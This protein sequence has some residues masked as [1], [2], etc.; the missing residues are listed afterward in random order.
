M[1]MTNLIMTGAMHGAT[2]L[3]SMLATVGMMTGVGLLA[4]WAMERRIPCNPYAVFPCACPS[5]EE[6]PGG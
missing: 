2:C 3:G 6:I 4:V 5:R 1:E